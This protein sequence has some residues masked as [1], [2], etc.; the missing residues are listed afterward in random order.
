MS[1]WLVGMHG[2]VRKNRIDAIYTAQIGDRFV[3]TAVFGDQRIDLQAD[4]EML[5]SKEFLDK[6][7]N[8][9]EKEVEQE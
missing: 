8:E 4:D 7:V 9:L 6:C 2:A 1:E 3:V 5:A